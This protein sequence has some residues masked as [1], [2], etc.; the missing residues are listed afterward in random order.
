MKGPVRTTPVEI[1]GG[2]LVAGF[3]KQYYVSSDGAVTW[4]KLG[5]PAPILSRRTFTG[6]TYEAVVSSPARRAIYI[7]RDNSEK[8]AEA[9]FRLQL[10]E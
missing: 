6:M 3:E 7:W 8:P 2:K 4:T 5:E 9:I 10:P 1:A